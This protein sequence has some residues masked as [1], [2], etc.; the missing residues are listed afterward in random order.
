MIPTA[1]LRTSLVLTAF[2]AILASSGAIAQGQVQR[3]IYCCD[4]QR[5]RPVCGDV[6]PAACYGKAYR[7]ISP[8]GVLRRHVAAPPTTEE[9]AR[10]D[11]EERR[12]REEEA[13]L[14]V[15]R[16][17]DRA[18]LETYLSL[19]DIDSREARELADIERG[20]A[21]LRE[22]ETELIAQRARY[23]RESEFYQG[24]D[25]PRE[26]ESGLRII[27]TERNANMKMIEARE[28]EMDAV[29]VRYAADRRRYAELIA[30]GEGQR[31]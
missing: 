22:R 5:G 10:R 21:P 16:R 23:E 18:L 30:A 19:D 3:S 8:Q 31:Q 11:A 25:L 20:I 4:D 7:E 1:F 29:R 28:A 14:E 26:I 2:A 12:R 27:E 17:L 24:R 13:R 9:I 6:L 15:Q